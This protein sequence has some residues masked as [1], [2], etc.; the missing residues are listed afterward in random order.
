MLFRIQSPHT[1]FILCYMLLFFYIMLRKK[2][3]YL[4]R[5]VTQVRRS[6]RRQIFLRYVNFVISPLN[7]P[8]TKLHNPVKNLGLILLP[9]HSVNNVS[10]LSLITPI[11]NILPPKQLLNKP[12]HLHHQIHS[13]HIKS[14]PVKFIP[15]QIPK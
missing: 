13:I 14:S 11:R 6:L 3:Q 10:V 8:L 1:F 12:I 2:K 4:T 5:R 15:K 9:I 7:R